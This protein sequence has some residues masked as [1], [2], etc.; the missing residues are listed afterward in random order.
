MS[1]L[2]DSTLLI[3]HSL[4]HLFQRAVLSGQNRLSGQVAISI[5]SHSA[6]TIQLIVTDNGEPIH[7]TS[8][9]T[10]KTSQK[11]FYLSD[12]DGFSLAYIFLTAF[13]STSLPIT[14]SSTTSDLLTTEVELIAPNDTFETISHKSFT[15]EHANPGTMIRLYLKGDLDS[16]ICLFHSFISTFCLQQLSVELSYTT[17]LDSGP[18]LFQQ[19]SS[20]T[21]L[22]FPTAP[23]VSDDFQRLA[24][25]LSECFSIDLD[26]SVCLTEKSD[27]YSC[28]LFIGLSRIE[29]A[30][31]SEEERTITKVMFVNNFPHRP[32]G[33][34]DLFK[35]INNNLRLSD[36]GAMTGKEIEDDS[37]CEE[38][39]HSF[40]LSLYS[41]TRI[42][43]ITTTL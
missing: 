5:S 7:A 2:Y 31:E 17:D 8:I 12:S 33:G 35:L 23:M 34:C 42:V 41:S 10:M 28:N 26:N 38:F 1:N 25:G 40:L 11:P 20:D 24:F 22:F 29:E 18:K 4:E 36:L 30:E 13:R 19:T 14:V 3:Y 27:R 16:N 21:H 39:C 6:D 43:A 37:L 9:T 32:S 15:D